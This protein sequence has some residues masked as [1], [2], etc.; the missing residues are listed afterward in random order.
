MAGLDIR[1][2]IQQAAYKGPKNKLVFLPKLGIGDDS[3][4]SPIRRFLFTSH[5]C[6]TELFL[7]L[8][9]LRFGKVNLARYI[10]TSS[11]ESND[12]CCD[13]IQQAFRRIQDAVLMYANLLAA[14]EENMAGEHNRAR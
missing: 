7:V 2:E 14:L 11:E 13:H 12:L 1:I 5:N 8:V 3:F 6:E 9:M 4:L 10:A